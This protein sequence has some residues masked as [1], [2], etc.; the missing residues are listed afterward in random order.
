MH[1][2][3]II[4]QHNYRVRNVIMLGTVM[5]HIILC[6]ILHLVLATT[7]PCNNNCDFVISYFFKKV[8]PRN[9]FST[10][11]NYLREKN[12]MYVKFFFC[13]LTPHSIIED[14]R[15]CNRCHSDHQTCNHCVIPQSWYAIQF[16]LRQLKAWQHTIHGLFYLLAFAWHI[17]RADIGDGG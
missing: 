3:S 4:T 7:T 15:N 11:N 13:R 6:V 8:H 14:R 12:I 5:L 10:M 17:R 16:F 9:M 1:F 2:S